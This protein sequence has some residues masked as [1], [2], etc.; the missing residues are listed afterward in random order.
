MNHLPRSFGTGV[1]LL[2]LA[3]CASTA[4]N[5]FNSLLWMQSSAEYRAN[6]I[7]AYSTALKN[8]DAAL[9]DRRWTAAVEQTGECSSL[10]PAVVMDIDE[11]VLDN[12]KYMGTVVLDNGKWSPATW[13][14]WVL[15]KEAT[16][17]PGAVE[18]INAMKAK[19]VRVIFVTNRECGKPAPPGQ[20]CLQQAATIEN[21]TR[22]GVFDVS[23]DNVLLKGEKEGWGSE[24]K[25]RREEVSKSFRIVMLFGDDLGDFLPGVKSNITPEERYRLVDE[26]R[27]DWGRKWFML[28]NPTCGS[29]LDI[30]K[31]PM[32]QYLMK[33]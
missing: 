14:E 24:K 2:L 6:T 3:G 30:L 32:S 17:I 27:A 5:N 21:L 25:S 4:N 18:F 22:V 29:W 23:P 31:D 13:E 1:F 10:P 7:Q 12:S 8:I 26:H 16:A 33:Y 19:R 9:A 15:R 20:E 28:P 11:T